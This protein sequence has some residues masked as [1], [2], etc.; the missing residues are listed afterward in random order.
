M[1][2]IQRLML[3]EPQYAAPGT[4]MIQRAGYPGPPILATNVVDQGR[5]VAAVFSL[6]T[7]GESRF[8]V[9]PA[10]TNEGSW[11][12]IEEWEL[13]VAPESSYSANQCSPVAGDA[14]IW[15][16][17]PGFAG[18]LGQ[19]AIYVPIAGTAF[20]EKGWGGFVGFSKWSIFVWTADGEDAIE[21]FAR[22][23]S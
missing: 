16:G 10:A 19:S 23:R 14:F 9:C 4:I 7:D 5:N 12:A 22:N 6:D 17:V 2:A 1:I 21:L 15:D 18:K 20:E 8:K 11:L 3:V 13:R